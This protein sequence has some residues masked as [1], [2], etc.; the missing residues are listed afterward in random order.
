MA[1]KESEVADFVKQRQ[2]QEN[3]STFTVSQFT[4]LA[5]LATKSKI[6]TFWCSFFVGGGGY[7][8]LQCFG[9]GLLFFILEAVLLFSSFSEPSCFLLLL[10]IHLLQCILAVGK[11]DEVRN[12]AAY[13]LHEHE[14]MGKKGFPPPPEP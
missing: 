1:G 4:E 2:H 7:F 11:V 14:Y 8:Y 13:A 9:M 10:I 6:I 5:S 3:A 12:R